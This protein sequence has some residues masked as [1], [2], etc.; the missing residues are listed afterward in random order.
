M[1]CF[2]SRPL[3]GFFVLSGSWSGSNDVIEETARVFPLLRLARVKRLSEVTTFKR[4]V[5]RTGQTLR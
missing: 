2:L 5:I 1:L 4:G 3:S